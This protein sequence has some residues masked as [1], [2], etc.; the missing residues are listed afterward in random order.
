MAIERRA[1]LR[2]PVVWKATITRLSG[3]QILG[4]TD[5]VARDGLNIILSKSLGVGESVTIDL[6]TK[7]AG[8][9]CYFRMQGA[10][11]YIDPLQSNLGVAVG[12][13][14]HSPDQRFEALVIELEQQHAGQSS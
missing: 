10:T 7:C 1:N 11:V 12:V 9:T 6:V 2:V 14:L 4:S 8:Q 13:A 5:N 3:E